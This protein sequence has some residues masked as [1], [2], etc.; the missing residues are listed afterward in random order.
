MRHRQVQSCGKNSRK[1]TRFPKQG[2]HTHTIHTRQPRSVRTSPCA[3]MA[4][5]AMSVIGIW[6]SNHSTVRHNEAS[7]TQKQRTSSQSIRRTPVMLQYIPQMIASTPSLKSL[8]LPCKAS[9]CSKELSPHPKQ[10]CWEAPSWHQVPDIMS[11]QHD[12][13]DQANLAR[14]SK[15]SLQEAILSPRSMQVCTMMP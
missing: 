1:N 3:R 8:N 7:I 13:A 12:Q 2:T 15:Q 14:V 5:S 6:S 10:M 4:A 9:G 11:D